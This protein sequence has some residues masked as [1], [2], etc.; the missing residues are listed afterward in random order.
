[1]KIVS[2]MAIVGIAAFLV[3]TDATLGADAP[4][5]ANATLGEGS[6]RD[7]S[8]FLKDGTVLAVANRPAVVFGIVSFLD[9][10]GV[11]RTIKA[12]LVDLEKTFPPR[13]TGAE[14][15]TFTN[16]QLDEQP[17]GGL[18]IISSPPPD[19]DGQKILDTLR[20]Q[21]RLLAMEETRRKRASE[22]TVVVS[23]PISTP[24]EFVVPRRLRY[25]AFSLP[26]VGICGEIRFGIGK[27][28]GI[29]KFG[30]PCQDR[31]GDDTGHHSSHRSGPHSVDR[32]P[33]HSRDSS[34]GGSRAPDPSG[35]ETTKPVLPARVTF[36]AS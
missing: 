12:G 24:E 20:E 4:L 33:D 23:Q 36:S 15:P 26:S 19:P 35:E 21:Q 6:R 11:A 30:L 9:E 3:F 1:M 18:S 28:G 10:D 8:V 22:E 32:D 5:G 29:G 17:P 16:Q 34:S 14:L 27:P 13:A 25:P 2:R 7:Y 31:F